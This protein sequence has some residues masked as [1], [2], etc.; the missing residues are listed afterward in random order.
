MRARSPQ[1]SPKMLSTHD[2]PGS[3]RSQGRQADTPGK[4]SIKP[5]GSRRSVVERH[6]LSG[7]QAST[8]EDGISLRKNNNSMLWTSSGRSPLDI[9]GVTDSISFSPLT[10]RSPRSQEARVKRGSV[11]SSSPQQLDSVQRRTSRASRASASG[12][13][14]L[15]GSKYQV[16]RKGPGLLHVLCN[17]CPSFCCARPQTA[18]VPLDLAEVL[19]GSAGLTDSHGISDL[20]GVGCSNDDLTPNFLLHGDQFILEQSVAS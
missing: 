3:Q 6:M 11:Q 17:L 12:R 18:E 1:H 8:R 14:S 9:L 16:T 7:R 10:N 5:S 15:A 20:D 4:S 19:G 2:S 13:M